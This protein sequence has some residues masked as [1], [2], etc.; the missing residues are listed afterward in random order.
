MANAFVKAQFMDPP[1][2]P[3]SSAPLGAVKAG[4]G[5]SISADGTISST[6]SGGTISDIVATN[7]IQ[8]GG[9]GPQVFVGLL[10]PTDSTIGGVRTIS[11][12]GISIDA[13]GVIRSV[14]SGN[15]SAGI[16][17][18]AQDLGAGSYRIS[19][20]TAGVADTSLG[21]VFVP[22]ASGLTLAST[23]SLTLSPPAGTAIGGV[24]AGSGVTI[25]VDGTLDAT[26]SGGTITG[27]GAG[28][29]L[30]GGGSAGAVTLFLRPA[31]SNTIGGVYPGENV[32]IDPDGRINVSDAALGVLTVSGNDPIFI[33][34]TSTNP[35]VNIQPASIT[36]IG[37][38]TLSSSTTSTSDST[39]ANSLA[40]KTVAD[41]ANA[42]LPLAGGT[43]TGNIT[44]NTGQT[45]PTVVPNSAY[46]SKGGI[47]AG[48]SALPGDYALLGVGVN[49]QVLAANSATTLGLEWI[50]AG[51]GTV[52][53]VS[54]TAPIQVATG[55]TTPVI[56]VSA[57]SDTN[58]GVVQLES[59][60]SSTSTI[61]APSSF[62]LSVVNQVA[63]NCLPKLGGTMSGDI[64]FSATQTFPGTLPLAGG[65]MTGAITFNAGQTFPG[66]I[67]QGALSGTSPIVVGGTLSNP[68]LSVST[69]TALALGVVRPDGTTITING[70][71]VISAAAG[72]S[73]LPLAGG[74]MTGDIVFAG[75]QT[76]PGVLP[77]TGGNLTGNLGINT[78]TPTYALH[79]GGDIG[80]YGP[81]NLWTMNAT[82]GV[83]QIILQNN[84]IN[85]TIIRDDPLGSTDII[86]F[87]SALR[88]GADGVEKIEIGVNGSIWLGGDI[89]GGEPYVDIDGTTGQ[90]RINGGTP[91]SLTFP[92]AAGTAG[93]VLATDGV[94]N[95]YWADSLSTGSL[96][97]T[98]G[99]MTGD[100]VFAGTQ[101]F[102][103]TIANSLLTTTGDIIFASAASTPTRLGIGAAGTILAV[104][105]GLPAY[106]TA[107]Q[108]GLLTSAA[109][110]TTYA[111]LNSPTFTGPVIVNGGGA[112][113][114]NAF[115]ISGGNLVLATTFTPSSSG[116][117]GSTGEFSWDTD[118]LYI[119]VSPNTWGRVAIDL[120]P[121]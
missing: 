116:D 103:D 121:F 7:G 5:I 63:L 97:L 26:G 91:G 44:F 46:T 80:S 37:A 39:A 36:Q 62:A 64:T 106:R 40:V 78:P 38:V 50:T 118:Y 16:G 115:T 110:A 99:T 43:M 94:G 17:I 109:A 15:I 32:T 86:T 9:Q 47:L 14:A 120:T 48:R 89:L 49:G 98:G 92:L 119:C 79:V 107:I 45:F 58:A 6:N 60:P 81:G 34:G 24:K 1:G 95:A 69:A 113:G 4:A 76:F 84:G 108:L 56:S 73:S 104:N 57:A 20:L 22:P 30:G 74:T 112:P 75:T 2:G 52:T 111:P 61:T 101:T 29:G 83:A 102:P 117:T 33:T 27:V 41:V 19:L 54:G 53:N 51:T 31:T 59:D 42:A 28:T 114:S 65:T 35:V 87:D 13:N 21:G 18:S 3:N 90:L 55:T 70:S 11:G 68:I 66:V 72:G 96:P 85:G 82:S 105:G 77:L 10:P 25:G 88:L 8:G 23:G 93:Q 100:I 12:S 71:G 67:A